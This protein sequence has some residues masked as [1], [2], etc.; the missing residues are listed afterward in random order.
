VSQGGHLSEVGGTARGSLGPTRWASH[1]RHN[2]QER[3]PGSGSG[4]EA[5]FFLK[6]LSHFVVCGSGL[7]DPFF[8][9]W[10]ASR[11]CKLPRDK[12]VVPVLW[13]TKGIEQVGLMDL[14]ECFQD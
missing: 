7:H 12:N 3:A 2:N 1:G 10:R 9:L 14:D 4:R 11:H 5:T 6:A 13:V 8:H